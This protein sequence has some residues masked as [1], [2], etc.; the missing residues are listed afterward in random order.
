MNELQAWQQVD[1][2]IDTKRPTEYDQA[3]ALLGDLRDMS[4]RTGRVGAYAERPRDLRERH[5]R[6]PSLMERFDR[7]KLQQPNVLGYTIRWR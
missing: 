2:L 5:A 3:V 4:E 7:A 1:E 6:K